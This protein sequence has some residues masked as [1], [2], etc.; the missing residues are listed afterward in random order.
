[1][2]ELRNVSVD[3]GAFALRDITFTIPARAFGVVVGAAG[4]GKTTLLEAIAGVRALRGGAITLGAHD[5]TAVRAELRNVGLVYQR[6]AL[7]THRT[8]LENIAWSTGAD[9]ASAHDVVTVL[10]IGSLL[11]TP[12]AAL[13]GGER[14]LVALARALVRVRGCLDRGELATLLLDEPF[15]ALDPRRRV[16]TRNIVRQLHADWSL[17]T[18]QVTHDGADAR[19]ADVAV[20]LDAG[21]VVQSG[22]PEAMLRTPAREDVP[23]FFA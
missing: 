2:I 15:S 4:A 12:V 23:L 11:P 14:Q 10:G 16:A 3:A 1:V 6:G 22:P 17:T 20:L 19:R 18:L 9:H 5:V 21:A 13:S 8:V 7:F